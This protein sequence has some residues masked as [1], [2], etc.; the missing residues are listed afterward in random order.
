MKF[1]SK[2]LFKS[3]KLK[4]QKTINVKYVTFAIT[5]RKRDSNLDLCQVQRS[6]QLSCQANKELVIKL[7]L[8]IIG[9]DEDMN[10]LMVDNFAILARQYFGSI[11]QL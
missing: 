8:I 3:N 4:P 9:K 5:K 7:A 1:C 2:Q 6:N 10:T 11:A